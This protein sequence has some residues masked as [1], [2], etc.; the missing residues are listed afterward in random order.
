MGVPLLPVLR[1]AGRPRGLAGPLLQGKLNLE[2]EQRVQERTAQLEHAL[3]MREEFLSV[4]SHELK[5]PIT[6]LQLYVESLLRSNQRGT[7]TP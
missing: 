5:T 3:W 1:G 4:A 6:S 2:L 7:L